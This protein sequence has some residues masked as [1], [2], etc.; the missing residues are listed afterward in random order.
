VVA[1]GLGSIFCFVLAFLKCKKKGPYSSYPEDLNFTT[2]D[3][4]YKD[5]D[6]DTQKGDDKDATELEMI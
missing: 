5:D 6:P 3:I 2:G 1:V 4:E